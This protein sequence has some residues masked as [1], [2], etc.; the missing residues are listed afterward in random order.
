MIKEKMILDALPDDWADQSLAAVYEAQV[1]IAR[2]IALQTAMAERLEALP[3]EG[4]ENDRLIAGLSVDVDQAAV[5][6]D[7]LS[8]AFQSLKAI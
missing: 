6:I 5:F 7:G 3:S 4:R 8:M 1:A 2:L